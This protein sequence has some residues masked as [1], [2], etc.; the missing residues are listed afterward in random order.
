MLVPVGKTSGIFTASLGLVEALNKSGVKAALFTP[1]A[2][3]SLAKCCANTVS[4]C[5]AAKAIAQGNKSE[6]LEKIVGNYNALKASGNFDV[7]V[8]EGVTDTPFDK[9]EINADI[10]HA[11]DASI[12]T[13]VQG[14]CGCAKSAIAATLNGHSDQEN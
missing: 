14:A 13:L 11:F 2:N 12:V 1:L 7:I 8:I 6:V 9:D 3:C 5:C 4:K 10:C